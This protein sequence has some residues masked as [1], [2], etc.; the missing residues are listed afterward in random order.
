MARQPSSG[1]PASSTAGHGGHPSPADE[2]DGASCR[3]QQGATPDP[4][5][6]GVVVEAHDMGA[7]TDGI[8]E[9]DVEVGEERGVNGGFRRLRRLDEVGASFR[10]EAGDVAVRRPSPGMFRVSAS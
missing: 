4:R 8:A 5:D 1:N 6:Q 9:D 2:A 3:H 10:F 7:V